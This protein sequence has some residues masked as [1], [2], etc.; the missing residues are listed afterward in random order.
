MGLKNVLKSASMGVREMDAERLTDRFISD[1]ACV[2]VQ[3]GQQVG[4]I[5]AGFLP[6]LVCKGEHE[7]HRRIAEGN[8]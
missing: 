1:L 3:T 2:Y 5:S 8:R 7:G 6:A 4:V